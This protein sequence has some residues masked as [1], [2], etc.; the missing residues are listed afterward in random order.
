[1][2]TPS[3]TQ[4]KRNDLGTLRQ[5]VSTMTLPVHPLETARQARRAFASLAPKQT[6]N[7]GF[8]YSCRHT[9]DK[10]APDDERRALRKPTAG[11]SALVV[12]GVHEVDHFSPSLIQD[13]YN[14]NIRAI[15]G[16]RRHVDLAPVRIKM[17]S[18]VFV[19]MIRTCIWAVTIMM[20]TSSLEEPQVIDMLSRIRHLDVGVTKSSSVHAQ[21]HMT[22]L[23]ERRGRVNR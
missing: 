7:L 20:M 12:F 6:R 23:C 14:H 10:R 1:L 13:W 17:R 16:E 11:K 18:P 5:R 21:P 15:V 2:R 19:P 3:S 8:P 4:T 9:Q 22:S